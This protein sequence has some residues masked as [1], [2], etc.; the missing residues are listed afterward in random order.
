MCSIAGSSG[1]C[2]VGPTL[3]VIAVQSSPNIDADS[4]LVRFDRNRDG[5]A[6]IRLVGCQSDMDPTSI[7]FRAAVFLILF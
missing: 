6:S 2:R 4:L 5:T 3:S 7:V 1:P